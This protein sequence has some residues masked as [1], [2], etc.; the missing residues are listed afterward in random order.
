M[1]RK[2]KAKMYD[3]VNRIIYLYEKE[4]LNIKEIESILKSEGYD[5][6]KSAI[7]RTLKTHEELAEE[8]RKVAEET[9]A[10]VEELKKVPASNLMEATLTIL[11]NKIFR[12][13]KNIEEL[14]F[15]E[16]ERLVQAM[17]RLATSIEKMQRYR[18]ELEAKM[19]VIEAEAE[20]RNIDPEFMQMLKR[21]IYGQ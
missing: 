16:P 17:N 3:I 5:I 8:Y 21:E 14:E 11:A 18:E 2:S 12:F 19:K 4:K 15:D 7:H 10:L 20:K 13:V 9:K 6:S 1:G